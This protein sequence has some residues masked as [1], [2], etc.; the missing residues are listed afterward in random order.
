MEFVLIPAGEFLM[1]S[2][3]DE[4]DRLIQR[5][6]DD[7]RGY[8]K[9]ELPQ[10]QVR[11]SQPFYLGKYEVTQAEWQ[12]VMEENPCHFT[13]DPYLPV[14]NV[15][16]EDMQAFIQ[17]LHEKEDVTSYRLPTE[18]E[19]EYAC[20]AGSTTAYSF[21]DDPEQLGEYARYNANSNEE[22]HPVG[23]RKP[24][25]FGLYDMHGNVWEWVQDWYGSYL[26]GTATNPQGPPSGSNRVARG[27]SW[28][29]D[30]GICR[31]AHR[32]LSGPPGYRYD[33]LGFRL[34]RTAP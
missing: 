3:P 14:E 20:R 21:G 33:I 30:A 31:S 26:P 22:V 15:S 2:S 32:G 16:W 18:A 27:G 10:H 8:F 25:T 5:Y 12:A 6:G 34:L 29:N 17:R 7:T 9:R 4:I 28:F 24:N 1:G 11:I 19:W 13:G 23:Q